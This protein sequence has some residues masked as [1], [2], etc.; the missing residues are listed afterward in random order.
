MVTL[1]QRKVWIAKAMGIGGLHWA[2]TRHNFS[3]QMGILDCWLR[4][5]RR[6]IEEETK[7]HG[8]FGSEESKDCQGNA[9]YG[10]DMGNG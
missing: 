9:N 6:L 10:I 7:R 3:F 8:F 1:D 2:I 5:V 4:W